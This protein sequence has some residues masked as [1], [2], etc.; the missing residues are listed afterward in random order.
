MGNRER[1]V[2]VLRGVWR[3]V[4]GVYGVYGFGG[5]EERER[6][7]EREEGRGC[8]KAGFGWAY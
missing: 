5:D 2:T 6:E 3:R 8:Q 1:C 4:F 7:R